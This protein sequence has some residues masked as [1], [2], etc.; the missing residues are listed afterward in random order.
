MLNYVSEII[1][2]ISPGQRVIALLLLL[3]SIVAIS[4]G[5]SYID[6]ASLDQEEF[7]AQISRQTVKIK[8]LEIAVDSLDVALMQG[9]R[10]CTDMMVTREK[11]FYKMLDEIKRD[12]R[13]ASPPRIVHERLITHD[14]LM[15]MQIP[16][17]QPLR[18]DN[19]TLIR[20]I[21]KMQKSISS[22]KQ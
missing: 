2:K 15:M 17:P 19:S 6:A 12:L 1:S 11:E 21:D 9:Q 20:K 14:T 10:S 18:P 16:E 13:A 3:L 7:N 22:E 8:N 4:L 5:P